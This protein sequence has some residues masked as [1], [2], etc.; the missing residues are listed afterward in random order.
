M[1]LDFGHIDSLNSMRE[2]GYL[3]VIAEALYQGSGNS[4]CS[5]P[6]VN[7]MCNKGDPHFISLSRTRTSALPLLIVTLV[8]PYFKRKL[9]YLQLWKCL[10]LVPKSSQMEVETASKPIYIIPKPYP[11]IKSTS[12]AKLTPLYFMV[13]TGEGWTPC[14]ETLAQDLL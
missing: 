10:I 6:L 2:D 1:V 12:S 8:M 13:E 5:C 9:K 11:D 3:M 14:P 4:W 7:V